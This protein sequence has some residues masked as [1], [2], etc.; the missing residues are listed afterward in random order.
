M[1]SFAI[2]S[3]SA[4]DFSSIAQVAN[5]LEALAE[6][7]RKDFIPDLIVQISDLSAPGGVVVGSELQ[8]SFDVPPSLVTARVQNRRG[9][10]R[11]VV[12]IGGVP[13]YE[14]KTILIVD[15][16][17]FSGNTMLAVVTK[18]AEMFPASKIGV[19]CIALHVASKAGELL[20]ERI[21]GL[22]FAVKTRNR[23]M[24]FPWGV[25]EWYG[26]L[27]LTL[28][29]SNLEINV[30]RRPWGYYE[31]YALKKECTVRI[32]TLYANQRMSLQR[33]L[34]RDEF[35]VPLDVGITYTLG[36]EDLA[37]VPGD[38]IF[39]PRGEWHRIMNRTSTKRRVL[40]VSFGEYDQVRDIE[41]MDDDYG[42]VKLDGSV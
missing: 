9:D 4:G 12:D 36:G 11:S 2:L 22:F 30:S 28:G 31:E 3:P 13:G 29:E 38:Y 42:R 32:H 25:A 33:H 35:F 1:S 16:V 34:R 19:G 10:V 40:E 18:I 24:R 23:E 5:A 15:D 21:E 7:L 20:K 14:N 37:T 6:Q 17:I 27:P 39:V 26:D 41:R 8:C